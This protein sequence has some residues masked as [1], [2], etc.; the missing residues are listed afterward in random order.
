[1]HFRVF[2]AS[3]HR[4]L[5]S[6]PIDS[7]PLARFESDFGVKLPSDYCQFLT[8]FSNGGA[9]PNYGPVEFSKATK[10]HLPAIVF[11][12]LVS[13]INVNRVYSTIATYQARFGFPT[14]VARQLM[15]L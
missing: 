11:H 4:Y 9:G 13:H 5:L 2:G 14:M 7:Q 6:G 12:R 1:M 8:L 15:C 10:G 3:S